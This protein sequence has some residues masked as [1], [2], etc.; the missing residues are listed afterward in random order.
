L[1]ED[2]FATEVGD[3]K[4]NAIKVTA[5]L[6]DQFRSLLIVTDATARHLPDAAILEM[7]GWKS[8]R[9]FV[10]KK[11]SRNFATQQLKQALAKLENLDREL[12]TSTMPPH[13]VLDLIIADI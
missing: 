9:L 2:Y 4:A 13:V 12:K 6:A 7:T 5:L 1:L 3:D 8:G 10:M 11:L